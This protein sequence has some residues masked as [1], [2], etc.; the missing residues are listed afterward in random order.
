MVCMW[1]VDTSLIDGWL[2]DLDDNSTEQIL[3]AL[4]ILRDIG[5]ALGRP[6]VDTITGSRHKNMKEL[7][8]G[9]HGT[10]ELRVL[11]AFDPERKAIMLVA[12]NKTGN[13]KKWYRQNIPIADNLFDQHKQSL[14]GERNG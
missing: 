1:I 11:F 4:E 10:S 7:R 8:P 14:K 12:G 5:P 13:W 2:D 3:A 9:S 6:L